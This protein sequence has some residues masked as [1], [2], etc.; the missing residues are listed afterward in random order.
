MISPKQSLNAHEI[1]TWMVSKLAELLN[2]DTSEIDIHQ[3]LED[4]GLDSSRAMLI[5]TQAEKIFGVEISPTMLW[6]YPTIA[7]LSQ[8]LAEDVEETNLIGNVINPNLAKI[9]DTSLD[10]Q[11]EVVLDPRIYPPST[12]FIFNPNP[13]AVFLTGGTGFLGAFIIRELLTQTQADI[14]CLTRGKTIEEGKNKLQNN[15][16]Q[17][18]IWNDNLSHRIIP[19]LG[20]LSQ[21]LLGMNEAEFTKLGNTIDGIYHSGAMLNYVFPYAAMK[22]TNVLG[23]QEIL[24]LACTGKLKPVHL[25]SSVAVFESDYYAGKVVKEDDDFDHWEGIFL[26]YS[27]TKWVAEK[28]VKLG[29]SRGIPITIHRPPLIAGDSKTGVC[30]T[31]D[32]INLAI[33]GCLQMGCFPDVNYMLDISPVDYVSK[34]IVYL[35]L[36]QKSLGHAFHLQHPEPVPFMDMVKWLQSFGFPI[37][38]IPY[39]E[40]QNRLTTD[41]VTPE[42]PLY[43]LRPFLLERWSKDKLTVPD[44]YLNAHRPQISCAAT[45]QALAESSIRCAPLDSKLFITY[46]SYLI[47]NGFLEV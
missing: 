42:N 15:L 22:P 45:Q 26:G 10:L 4:Y 24:R 32:F 20:D 18:Y 14:Y 12:S 5:V 37:E 8:R 35:S 36:Q 3:P 23:T 44:L 9:A 7:A 13:T 19:V 27:Q 17:Y 1:Q 31:D 33:K 25:V 28:L 41:L 11:A 29:Y 47:Q 30:N 21:P 40:W 16:A 43:T 39:E 46:S 6:H 34:S 38:I 2:V